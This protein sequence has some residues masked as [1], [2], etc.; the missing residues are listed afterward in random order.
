MAL[1]SKKKENSSVPKGRIIKVNPYEN[2]VNVMELM[3][4][5]CA[6]RPTTDSDDYWDIVNDAYNKLNNGISLA[7]YLSEKRGSLLNEDFKTDLR[8]WCED[9]LH[10]L[11]LNENTNHT[12]VVVAGG[13]SSGKSSFLNI[14]TGSANLLPT[15]VEPTSVVKTYLYCSSSCKSIAVRGVNHKNTVV[16]LDKNVL[17]ALQHSNKNVALAS[18]LD[19]LF[20]EIPANAILSGIA[21]VDTPGYN[22]SDRANA[23]NGK[24]DKETAEEAMKEGE[25][26]LWIVDSEKGTITSADIEMI[27]KFSGKKVFIF[28]KADKKGKSACE[29]IVKQATITL[30][31]EF[32]KDEII[33]VLAYSTLEN[34]IY[35][36]YKNNK[37]IES[38]IAEC[39]KCGNGESDLELY[40]KMVSELFEDEIVASQKA[41]NDYNEKYKE[42][43]D[44][45]EYYELEYNECKDSKNERHEQLQEVLIDNYTE[46]S[47]FADKFIDSSKYALDKFLDFYNGVLNFEKNDHW[48]SSNILTNAINK[49]DRDYSKAV[50]K[51]NTALNKF[52][53]TYKED[54]RKEIASLVDGAYTYLLDSFKEKRDEARENCKATLQRIDDEKDIIKN[55]KAYKKT[56]CAALDLAITNYRKKKKVVVVQDADDGAKNVFDAIKKKNYNEFIQSFENGVDVSVC[57]ADGYNPLTFAVKMGN[58]KMVQ[59]LLDHNADPCLKDRKGYNAFHTAVENQYRNICELLLAEDPDLIDSETN[60]G[61]TAEDLAKKLTFNKWLEKEM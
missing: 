60:S 16:D 29:S 46:L 50:D 31:K 36:S 54:Y 26:L 47:D 3:A 23:S 38:V 17:Q 40:K 34:K 56:F 35:C 28:N 21:F 61:E 32:P 24:T 25:V 59:F 7:D 6:A 9:I 19:K 52:D 57:N 55:I 30:S 37:Q 8:D 45:Q 12:R 41:I 4:N 53:G 14:I 51:H 44:I 1:K 11:S 43:V 42:L 18:V 2:P 58:Y 10:E 20:V 48:G 15:G 13:F 33:D 39:K 5:I 49:A 22:N 27:K